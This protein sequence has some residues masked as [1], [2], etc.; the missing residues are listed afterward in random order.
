M[1][2]IKILNWF[3]SY[4]VTT[5]DDYYVKKY[6][7]IFFELLITLFIICVWNLTLNVQKVLALKLL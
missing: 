7:K 3:L 1:L 4:S 6:Y 2:K 5:L